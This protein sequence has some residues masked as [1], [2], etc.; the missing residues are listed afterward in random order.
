M[1]LS[2][3]S[4]LQTAVKSRLPLTNYYFSSAFTRGQ[5]PRCRRTAERTRS[6]RRTKNLRGEPPRNNSA[7][8]WRTRSSNEHREIK[9]KK[10]TVNLWIYCVR[11]FQIGSIKWKVPHIYLAIEFSR[12][13]DDRNVMDI[14]RLKNVKQWSNNS[15]CFFKKG[16]HCE[17][18]PATIK[19]SSVSHLLNTFSG[20][21]RV[22][23]I[24]GLIYFQSGT[25][26]VTPT[27]D[28][29]R[30][31]KGW[32]SLSTL[33][34]PPPMC[35]SLFSFIKCRPHPLVIWRGQAYRFL[36]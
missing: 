6:L 16:N 17:C 9:K 15:V 23:C 18:F 11:S 32:Y 1:H 2:P 29:P 22:I 25:P 3:N 5:R 35:R 20:G 30:R 4:H 7:L 10:K 21:L 12:W 13:V 27:L 19:R 26:S 28:M 34:A 36:K 8:F 14:F 33:Q 24:S 31:H